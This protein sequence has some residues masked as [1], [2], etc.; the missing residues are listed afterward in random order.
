MNP[1]QKVFRTGWLRRLNAIGHGTLL[2]NEAKS[3]KIFPAKLLTRTH[4]KSLP[5]D[6]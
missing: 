1:S 2:S 3:V 4:E 5:S 6:Y